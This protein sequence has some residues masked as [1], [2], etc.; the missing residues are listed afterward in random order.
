MAGFRVGCDLTNPLDVAASIEQ[1]GD[2]YLRRIYTDAELA[3][4][5]VDVPGHEPSDSW[6]H[7]PAG[8]S[9][10][11]LLRAGGSGGGVPTPVVVPAPVGRVRAVNSVREITFG[12]RP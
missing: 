6:F 9:R 8:A 10:A 12:A 1:F 4:W 7:L 2:R 3:W 5:C 11:V